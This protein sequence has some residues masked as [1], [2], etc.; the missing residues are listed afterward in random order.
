M[1]KRVYELSKFPLITGLSLIVAVLLMLSG[2]NSGKKGTTASEQKNPKCKVEKSFFGMTAEGDSA[3]LYTL[4]NERD[5]TVT[6]TNYGGIITG[7]YVPDKNGKTA[8]IVLGF[9]HLEPY[10][11][12][13]P[14]FGALVG[15]YANRIAGAAFTLDGVHYTLAANDGN[16]SLHG[17]LKGFDK[18]LWTP[19]VIACDDRFR[20]IAAVG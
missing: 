15:R 20:R 3:M 12:G 14:Y 6:I 2:C 8:N 9:D 4:K 11:E 16:N 7:I 1:D 10:L 18:K 13:H 19:E 5:I 17:G